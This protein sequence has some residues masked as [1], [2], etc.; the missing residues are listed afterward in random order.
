MYPHPNVPASLRSFDTPRHTASRDPL[1]QGVRH[2]HGRPAVILKMYSP[3]PGTLVT[4]AGK[5]RQLGVL[6]PIIDPGEPVVDDVPVPKADLGA[7]QS[8]FGDGLVAARVDEGPDDPRAVMSVRSAQ[9]RARQETRRR[10][11]EC[12][13]GMQT[14]VGTKRF[15]CSSSLNSLF[16]QPAAARRAIDVLNSALPPRA[17]SCSSAVLQNSKVPSGAVTATPLPTRS[18]SIWR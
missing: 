3:L 15:L 5:S 1:T 14:A 4:A 9:D 8:Q 10:S 11:C 13:Q 18:N 12:G 6:A 2:V 17:S 16:E 7:P